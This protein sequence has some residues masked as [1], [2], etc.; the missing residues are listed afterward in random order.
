M[1]GIWLILATFHCAPVAGS[2]RTIVIVGSVEAGLCHFG[3][4][5]LC[6]DH[7]RWDD[8][9]TAR[10]PGWGVLVGGWM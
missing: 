6:D 10:W 1:D 3:E 5:R 7:L 4:R 8:G 9:R 2:R